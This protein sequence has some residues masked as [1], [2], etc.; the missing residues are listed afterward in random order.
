M[1]CAQVPGSNK[2]NIVTGY[3]WSRFEPFEDVVRDGVGDS[4][5]LTFWRTC[6]EAGGNDTLVELIS[7]KSLSWSLTFALDDDSRFVVSH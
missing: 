5:C 1:M 6:T 2:A 3:F 4:V 7:I